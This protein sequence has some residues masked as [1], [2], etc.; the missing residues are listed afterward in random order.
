MAD[1]GVKMQVA[2]I[3]PPGASPMRRKDSGM[4][5]DFT[6]AEGRLEKLFP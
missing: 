1:A 4:T 2:G 6:E 5:R 3:L